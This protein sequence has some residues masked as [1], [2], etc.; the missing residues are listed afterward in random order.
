L[1]TEPQQQSA[2]VIDNPGGIAIYQALAIKQGLKACKIGMRVNR[3]YTPTNLMAMV[4]KITG[5]KFKLKQ[6]DE[7]IAAIEAWVE[8]QRAA[9][10]VLT[11]GQQA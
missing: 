8:Q 5:K 9:G 6:Y 10:V 1:N 7:A 2:L 4:L 3:A 11:E